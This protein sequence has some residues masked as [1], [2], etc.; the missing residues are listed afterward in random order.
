LPQDVSFGSTGR[1]KIVVILP[2]IVPKR[3]PITPGAS[4]TGLS[5]ATQYVGG[6]FGKTAV[7]PMRLIA[8][9]SGCVNASA[10]LRCTIGLSLPAGTA[11]LKLY[12][13]A[14]NQS[15]AKPLALSKSIKVVLSQ[16]ETRTIPSLPW[17]GIAASFRM[18]AYPPT[19]TQGTPATALIVLY[20]IDAAGAVI[21]STQVQQQ[22]GTLV[23]WIAH[24][25]GVYPRTI[26][27]QLAEP[28]STAPFYYDGRLTGT[29]KLRA[30]QYRGTTYFASTSLTFT[31]GVTGN[32]QAFVWEGM[33]GSQIN[34]NNDLPALEQFAPSAVG[35]AVPL[36]TYGLGAPAFSAD[37][38]GGFW[39]GPFNREGSPYQPAVPSWIERYDV[40]GKGTVRVV[41]FGKALDL[42]FAGAAVDVHG[43]LYAVQGET[44]EGGAPEC[45]LL[46]PYL[47]VFGASRSWTTVIR[48]LVVA[49]VTSRMSCAVPLAV[50]LRDDAFVGISNVNTFYSGSAEILEFGPG[51]SGNVTPTRTITFP[52]NVATI[53]GGLGTDSSGNLFALVNNALLRY[54]PEATTGVPVFP[55]ATIEAFALDAK[56]NIYAV[57][58]T[59]QSS[60]GAG[61]FA[62][63]EF[64]PGSTT[65]SRTIAGPHTGLS[66][67]SGI[68]V[69]P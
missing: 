24:G 1:G 2:V 44:E 34:G 7:A 25:S 23:R 38:A 36:R 58:K 22:D 46:D 39:A 53:I 50:D 40:T 12:T 63:E 4:P 10:G 31:P 29:E 68:A 59:G 47:Y 54:A 60:N 3:T 17:T 52:Q 41:P 14:S 51:T 15:T 6:S 61:I 64:A 26:E 55:G 18:A 65:P 48:K 16:G 45:S 66:T 35:D 37:A 67:P 57:V 5:S 13:Y 32:A 69:A 28:F 27:P 9:S 43:N 11:V 33:P 20:G 19:L 56:N 42:N 49:P 30:T 62:V 21:P 8:G